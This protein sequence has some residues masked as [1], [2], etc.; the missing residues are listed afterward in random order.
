MQPRRLLAWAIFVVVLMLSAGLT[1][2]AENTLLYGSVARRPSPSATPNCRDGADRRDSGTFD[3]CQRLEQIQTQKDV[4]ER[5]H[6]SGGLDDPCEFVAA[7]TGDTPT[8]RGK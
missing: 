1:A 2:S 8:C 6:P 7:A 5:S 3:Y 4:Y